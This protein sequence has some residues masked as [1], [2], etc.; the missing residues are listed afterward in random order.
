MND[1]LHIAQ[2]RDHLGNE[3]KTPMLDHKELQLKA[4]GDEVQGFLALTSRC[5]STIQIFSNNNVHGKSQR[6]RTE[7]LSDGREL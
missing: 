7:N 3:Q 5:L 1:I 4:A 6:K 2:R